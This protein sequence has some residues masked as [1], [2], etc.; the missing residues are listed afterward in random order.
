MK[1]VQSPSL[2]QAVESVHTLSDLELVTLMDEFAHRQPAILSF[3]LATEDEFADEDDF[4]MLLEL[5]VI[6][7]KAF[8]L[9]FGSIAV[10]RE[11]QVMAKE[12]HF[13][14]EA[15]KFAELTEQE[16]IDAAIEM[17]NRPLQPVIMNYVFEEVSDLQGNWEDEIDDSLSAV[18][19]NMQIV[20]QLLDDAINKP[21]MRVVD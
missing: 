7:W 21:N 10:V 20:V 18:V 16:M 9:E 5:T 4:Q 14:A 12:Q 3:V 8:L 13:A 6:A 15:L 11:D 1:I 19:A 2:E 17:Y